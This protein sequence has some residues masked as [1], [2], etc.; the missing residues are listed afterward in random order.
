MIID[1]EIFKSHKIKPIKTIIH[2]QL[3]YIASRSEDE[4]SLT[5]QAIK[6][7]AND[8]WNELCEREPSYKERE[9]TVNMVSLFCLCYRIIYNQAVYELPIN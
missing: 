6:E 5:W 3:V 4:P 1:F 8:I 9:F 7:K 2:F